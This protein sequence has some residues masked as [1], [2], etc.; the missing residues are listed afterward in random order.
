MV[1]KWEVK[2]LAMLEKRFSLLIWKIRV[3]EEHTLPPYFTPDVGVP[4]SQC[5]APEWPKYKDQNILSSRVK[6]VQTALGFWDHRLI[7]F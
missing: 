6:K 2:I 3:I 4:P 7:F 5:S 1:Q